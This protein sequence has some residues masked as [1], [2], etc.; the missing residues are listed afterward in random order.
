[1]MSDEGRINDVPKG[2]VDKKPKKKARKRQVRTKPKSTGGSDLSIV[3]PGLTESDCAQACSAKMCVISGNLTCA[4][5]RKGGLRGPDMSDPAALR[6]LQEAQKQ[7]ATT[8]AEK[9]FT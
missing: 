4:H 8:A 5:P 6:R 1:M 7:L 3:Y 2:W 9:R